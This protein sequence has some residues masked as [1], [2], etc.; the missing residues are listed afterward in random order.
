MVAKG[1][2]T[3]SKDKET[4]GF[5]RFSTEDYA[6][7][8][9]GILVASYR[10]ASIAA[11]GMAASRPEMEDGERGAI[12][13]TSSAAAQDGQ[14]GQVMLRL[15]QGRRER[16]GPADGSRPDGPWHPRQFDHARHLRHAADVALQGHEPCHVGWA[17]PIRSFPQAARQAGRICQPG[18][19]N[20]CA[21][22]ISTGRQFVS[23]ARS[24]CRRADRTAALRL[25]RRF[26]AWSVHDQAASISAIRRGQSFLCDAAISPLTSIIC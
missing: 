18:A 21:T 1:G 7:R 16:P 6:C 26:A 9:Q 22:S 10:V 20:W 5:K 25:L 3:V 13:L 4:G 17:E 19:W 15:G 2:K 23:T 11:L 12:V 24:G 14:V 8:R